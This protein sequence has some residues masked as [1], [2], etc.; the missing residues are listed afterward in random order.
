[1]LNCRIVLPQQSRSQWHIC[2]QSD[3]SLGL[4]CGGQALGAAHT[5]AQG[6]GLHCSGSK[7][8]GVPLSPGRVGVEFSVASGKAPPGQSPRRELE[9]PGY[10]TLRPR[11]PVPAQT[12]A[13]SE[14]APLPPGPRP[15]NGNS[16]PAPPLWPP[17]CSLFVFG[18]SP[19]YVPLPLPSRMFP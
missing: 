10:P 16:P 3:P 18:G 5:A 6:R 11:T 15:W 7:G 19:T 4:H 17:A 8:P 12:R 1:M 13:H 9:Y 14:A 2:L